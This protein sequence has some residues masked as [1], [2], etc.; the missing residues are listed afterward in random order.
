MDSRSPEG[1]FSKSK[2]GKPSSLPSSPSISQD[3]HFGN[4]Q[5]AARPKVEA[6]DTSLQPDFLEE[7]EQMDIGDLDLE[8]TEKACLN[9]VKCYVP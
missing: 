8:G 6:M 2:I 4:L 3:L 1:N 5:Q 9:K 7:L